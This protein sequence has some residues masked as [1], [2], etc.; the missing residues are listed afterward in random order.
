MTAMDM[1]RLVSFAAL[2]SLVVLA[3]LDLAFASTA[4]FQPLNTAMSSVLSFMTGTFA[5]TAATVAVAAVGYLALTSRIPW[6]W[7]FS[8]VIGVALIFGAAQVV[9]SLTSGMGG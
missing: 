8:V 9:S 2:A 7:A 5:T 1:R 4:T 3:S 6:M